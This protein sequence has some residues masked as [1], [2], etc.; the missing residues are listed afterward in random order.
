MN[1][2]AITKDLI[3]E[4]GA[5][6]GTNSNAVGLTGPRNNKL[7]AEMIGHS[8]FRKPFRLLDDDGDLYYEGVLV[9]DEFGPLD[10]FG[11]PNAGCTRIH[12]KENGIWTDI[13]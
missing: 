3:A 9:G 4:P 11:E 12:I 7:T 6:P 1:A 13:V 5:L 8:P 2:W 10:D